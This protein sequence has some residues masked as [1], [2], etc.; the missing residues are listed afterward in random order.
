[1][2]LGE[3]HF[4]RFWTKTTTYGEILKTVFQNLAGLAP[5]NVLRDFIQIGSLSVELYPNA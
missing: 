4:L 1:M 5:D 3:M 2:R